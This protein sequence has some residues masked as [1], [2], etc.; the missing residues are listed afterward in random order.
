M[1]CTW[2][3]ENDYLVYSC[4]CK[5]KIRQLRPNNFPLIHEGDPY[6]DWNFNCEAMKM[7]LA[8]GNTLG[9]FQ[10]EGSSGKR[11]SKALKPVN[12]HHTAALVAILRPG[13]VESIGEDKLSI[14][15]RYC[16]FKNGEK[17]PVP[18]IAILG[19]VLQ[20]NYY[21]MIYQE[22][23]IKIAKEIAGFTPVEANALRKGIGKKLPEII[24]GLKKTFL[25]GCKRVG[26]VSEEDAIKLF[27]SIEKSQR[28]SFPKSHAYEY[29]VL[30]HATAFAKV[31]FTD[32]FYT[33][34]LEGADNKQDELDARN[35]LIQD[36]KYFDIKITKPDLRYSKPWFYSPKLKSIL[37]GLN[38]VKSVGE[39]TI[40]KVKDFCSKES[41]EW[42][43]IL[44]NCLYKI[45]SKAAQ[46]II[47]AGIIENGMTR[48]KQLHEFSILCELTAEGQ[49]K[50][51][52]NNVHNYKNL[53]DLLNGLNRLKK[54]GGGLHSAKDITKINGLISLLESPP[55][56]LDDNPEWVAA[57]EEEILG[58]ALSA[59][60]LDSV[61]TNI[62]NTTCKD[63][64]VGKSTN[65]MIIKCQIDRVEE[66]LIKNG[67]NR[68]KKFIKIDISDETGTLNGCMIWPE[69]YQKYGHIAKERNTVCVKIYRNNMDCLTISDV[70][71]I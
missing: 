69:T 44:V 23:A 15:E 26:K 11:W 63:V 53:K 36:A 14:S 31:H 37:Y 50:W 49:I 34:Y 1:Y 40:K 45:N 2:K 39:A 65:N 29:A 25:E 54:D 67:K 61:S 41:N 21:Q 51:I 48:K 16:K 47:R 35:K 66:K 60:L 33:S 19:K 17:E 59:S 22:D 30:S 28:Y 9:V 24:A 20:D 52:F 46:N 13:C 10:L 57:S 12:I 42:L 6:R 18:D 70:F 71:Q 38:S 4:G 55:H 64:T 32:H 27:D 5:F 3:I 68:G 7:L 62:A 8:E 56:P 58:I 43:D